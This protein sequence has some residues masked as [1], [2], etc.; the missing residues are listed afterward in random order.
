MCHCGAAVPDGG[1]SLKG[2]LVIEEKATWLR[3]ERV[4]EEGEEVGRPQGVCS[5]PTQG[6]RD[7]TEQ[8]LRWE[9][10]VPKVT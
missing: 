5:I 10:Q 9:E 3:K 8:K 7:K 2:E 4:V 1:S 6:L